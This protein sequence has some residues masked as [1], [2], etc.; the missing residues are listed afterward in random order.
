M[1]PRLQADRPVLCL[2]TDR[3]RLAPRGESPIE[4]LVRQVT[5][6]VAAGVTLIQ[7]RERDLET[8]DLLTLTVR[9]VEIARWSESRII[10]N[11]RVDVALAARAAGVHLR[12]ESMAA[13][14]VR[15]IV[16]EG[17][18]IGRSVHTE[19]D[20]AVATEAGAVDYLIFGTVFPTAAKPPGHVVAGVDG[21]R[22]V[23]CAVDR[24]VLAIGG[25][26]PVTMPAV[27]RTPAAGFAAVSYFQSPAGAGTRS[28][29]EAVRAARVI[30]GETLVSPDAQTLGGA[31][32]W[33]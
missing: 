7:I 9:C 8:A 15:T 17:F 27:A 21:L 25:V 16:P 10:V 18:V 33:M 1:S 31:T 32:A 12:G 20:A 11:D 30:F 26:T 23:A 14:R 4:A 29:D 24:P 3:L 5:E 22:R 19:A 28:M 13:R 2:V 6:A